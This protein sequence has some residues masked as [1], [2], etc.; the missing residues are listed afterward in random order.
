MIFLP[1][2]IL[3][4]VYNIQLR[5]INKHPVCSHIKQHLSNNKSDKMGN[6]YEVYFRTEL[7]GNQLEQKENKGLVFNHLEEKSIYS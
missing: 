3:T 2:T 1:F 4:L 6:N 7:T 5:I